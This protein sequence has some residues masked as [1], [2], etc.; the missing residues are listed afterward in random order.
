MLVESIPNVSEGRDAATLAALV[1]AVRGV[2]GA[3][4]LDH[5]AD[6]AHHRSV[7]TIA[8]AP[9]PVTQAV[10]ALA[11]VAIAR[12]DLRHHDGVHPRVGAI[13]VIPFVPLTGATMDDCVTLAREVGATLASRHDLPVYLYEAAATHEERRRLEVIR[14]GNVEGLAARMRDPAWMPDYGPPRPHPTAGATV[15]GARAPLIAFN[16]WLESTDVT[17]AREIAARI[18]TSSGGLPCLK[19][20]GLTVAGGR[21]QVSMNLTDYTVTGLPAVYAAVAREAAALGVA[22]GPSE[23]IGLVPEAAIAGT[24]PS[25]VGLRTFSPRQI[26]ERRLADAD[27]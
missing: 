23:L 27:D 1:A 10:L 24:D 22:L 13:D 19:A 12:I 15:V 6:A 26:L 20:L 21:A 5:S 9:G 2:P 4:L 25:R 7:F 18:R 11:A 14:R 3:R 17:L 16:V 8:G